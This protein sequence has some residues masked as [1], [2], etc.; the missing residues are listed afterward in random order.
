MNIK[1]GEIGDCS[2]NLDDKDCMSMSTQSVSKS[3]PKKKFKHF[4]YVT[5]MIYNII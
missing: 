3:S 2:V 1:R 4:K 5:S